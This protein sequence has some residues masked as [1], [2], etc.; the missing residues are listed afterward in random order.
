MLRYYSYYSVGGYKDFLLGDSQSKVEA[1]YYF[2]LLPV[3]EERAKTDAEAKKQVAELKALPSIKQLSSDDNC[4]LP[5][6]ARILFSHAGYKLIYKHLEGDKYALALR[7]IS[8]KEKDEGG[9]SIPFLFVIVGD[10]EDV[11]TLDLL[12]AYM[13]SNIKTTESMLIHVL[14][15]DMEK[16]GLRFNLSEFNAWKD[17]II[18]E[19]R[20][21]SLACA[22]RLINIHA[23]PNKVGLLVLPNG[24]PVKVA[25]TEQKL[26]G[27]EVVCADEIEIIPKDDPDKLYDLLV[28]LIA[29]IVDERKRN[30]LLRK[31]LIASGVGG[32][33]AGF[34]AAICC[35][36]R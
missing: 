25:A 32:A 14:A 19:T 6:S 20:S 18:N 23:C 4:D 5:I 34:I 9:R 35:N 15:M 17:K 27:Y 3:L 11:R 24:I 8:N 26:Q 2:A 1:T 21:T 36:H 22:S 7:D 12:A 16:N 28:D 13:A 30:A 31:L 10:K 33:I 29:K